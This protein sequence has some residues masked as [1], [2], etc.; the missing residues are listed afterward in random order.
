MTVAVSLAHSN[1]ESLVKVQ[2][3]DVQNARPALTS[4]TQGSG[5]LPLIC[6]HGAA[7]CRREET[8]REIKVI[9]LSKI[10]QGT[11]QLAAYAV[12]GSADI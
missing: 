7:L 9:Q 11:K 10:V 12:A 3:R 4:Q 5:I 6:C 2:I 1:V 8:K